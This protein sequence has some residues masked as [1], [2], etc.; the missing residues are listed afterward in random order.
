MIHHIPYSINNQEDTMQ[1]RWVTRR[2]TRHARLINHV[3][4]LLLVGV[5]IYDLAQNWEMILAFI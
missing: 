3:G 2:L 5:G 1:E 4:G